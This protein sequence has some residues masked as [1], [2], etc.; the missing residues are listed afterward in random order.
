VVVKQESAKQI[1]AWFKIAEFVSRG[2]KERAL[3][4][5]RLL[6]HAID[7]AAFAQQLEGDILL[8]FNDDVAFEKYVQSAQLYNKDGRVSEAAAVYEHLITMAPQTSEK[9]QM[10]VDLYK[11]LSKQLR[12]FEAMQHFLRWLLS[13]KEF[14]KVSFILQQLDDAAVDFGMIHQELVQN[15]LHIE[16]APT[17]SLK[18]HV[19]KII[20]YYFQA[21]QQKALQTFL[22]TLKMLHA[23]LYEDACFYLQDAEHAKG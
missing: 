2:E 8:S 3:A 19:R 1:V 16:N 21:K 6:A 14:E 9:L 18:L 5:Y 22:M 7:D 13:H 12:T 20:D 11:Q 4:L 15:W 10:M 23:L 17:E